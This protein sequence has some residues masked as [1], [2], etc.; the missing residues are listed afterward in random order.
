M[1]AAVF[2]LFGAMGF[3]ALILAAHNWRWALLLAIVVGF[4]QDLIRKVM[5]GEPVVVVML[6]SVVVAAALTMATLRFGM[7]SLRPLTQGDKLAQGVLAAFVLLVLLQAMMAF[8]RFGSVV[9]PAIGVMFYLSPIPAIWL[10]ERYVRSINDYGRFIR[11]YVV[12]GLVI[13]LSMLVEKAGVQSIFFEEVG[14]GLVIYDQQ[15]GVLEAYNGFMRSPEIAAWH[16]GTAAAFLM[17]LAVSFKATVLRWVTPALVLGLLTVATFTGRRKVLVTVAAF[18]AVYFLL[19]MYYRQRTGIR[20]MFVSV[21]GGA[22]LVGGT[23]VMAPEQSASNPYVGRGTTVFAD[24]AERF[25]KLGLGSIEGAIDAAGLWGLGAGS[26]SQGTQYF[27]GAYGSARG[28]AE[29]GLGKITVE[30]GVPGLMLAL[31]SALLIARSLRRALAVAAQT[32]PELLRLNLGLLSLVV[33]NVPVFA[34]A[35]QVYGDPFVLFIL[36][37]CLGFVLAGPRLIQLRAR[38]ALRRAVKAQA[39]EEFT[40]IPV[41]LRGDLR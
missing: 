26:V 27:G 24:A 35:S 8:L 17:V 20:A 28:S 25:E 9:V 4:S 32:D 15:V 21:I 13:A 11:L 41:V 23:L 22:L 39:A 29:G 33:G 37:S 14:E 2:L 31:I 1:T 5:A 6:S 18:A 30:L 40:H 7:I 34:G 38:A 16:L 19:L 10:I 3:V 12:C 36:G